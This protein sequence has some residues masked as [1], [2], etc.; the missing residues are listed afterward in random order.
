MLLL[1][2]GAL[3]LVA[4][5][6]RVRARPHMPT[7]FPRPETHPGVENCTELWFTQVCRISVKPAHHTALTRAGH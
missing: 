3:A 2:L 4:S 5:S 6:G 1:L 7:Y